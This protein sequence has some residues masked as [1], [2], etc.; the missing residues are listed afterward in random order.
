M[1]IVGRIWLVGSE[2]RLR[3]TTTA[4]KKYLWRNFSKTLHTRI[5]VAPHMVDIM[6]LPIRYVLN[7][8]LF[9]G[10]CVGLLLYQQSYGYL[11]LEVVAWCFSAIYPPKYRIELI[12]MLSYGVLYILS[13]GHGHMYAWDALWGYCGGCY[14]YIWCKTSQTI[15][16]RE[17]QI[18]DYLIKVWLETTLLSALVD[19]RGVGRGTNER[20]AGLA[21]D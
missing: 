17:I 3:D 7:Y 18:R 13:V 11:L 16:I 19:E 15:Q 4:F 5:I 9:K 12:I 14:R 2:R 21:T 10:R 6:L 20:K 1:Y 8:W